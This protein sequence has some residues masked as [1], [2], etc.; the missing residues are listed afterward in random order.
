MC[1]NCA[2]RGS[3]REA[4]GCSRT[5]SDNRGSPC[6]DFIVYPSTETI[7]CHLSV[8]NCR[9]FRLIRSE[10]F[11]LLSLRAELIL[12]PDKCL[13]PVLGFTFPTPGTGLRQ[14]GSYH[15][16]LIGGDCMPCPH[17][18]IGIVS[19][20][21]GG[22][23]HSCTDAASYQSGEKIYSD[24]EGVWHSGKH[25]ERI[26]HTNILLPQNAPREYMNRSTL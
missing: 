25:I 6:A 19:R 16:H 14:T 23:S 26:V 3:L 15:G 5:A 10:P 21:N 18:S 24:Y 1:V 7:A 4:V 13:L 17:Y 2:L 9:Q 11:W 22:T 8:W 12:A 20:G